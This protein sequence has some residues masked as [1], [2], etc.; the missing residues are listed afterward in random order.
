[1][2]GF[3]DL[4]VC[5]PV[6]AFPAIERAVHQMITS[7]VTLLISLRATD[8]APACVTDLVPPAHTV[9]GPAEVPAGT[10]IQVFT[11]PILITVSPSRRTGR[12]ALAGKTKTVGIVTGTVACTA[13]LGIF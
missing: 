13:V 4:G 5:T 12:H 11:V 9:T 7:L 1:M 6:T 8:L 2:P 10:N 3:T